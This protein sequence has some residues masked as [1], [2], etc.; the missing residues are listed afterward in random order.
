MADH[1]EYSPGHVEASG[2]T[3]RGHREANHPPTLRKMLRHYAHQP[4]STQPMADIRAPSLPREVPEL[5]GGYYHASRP[6]SSSAAFS[7][8]TAARPQSSSHPNGRTSTATNGQTQSLQNTDVRDFAYQ[9]TS[10]P[11]APLNITSSHD[12]E[13]DILLIVISEHEYGSWQLYPALFHHFKRIRIKLL[14][15][16]RSDALYFQIKHSVE[17]L[18]KRCLPSWRDKRINIEIL[19]SNP[20]RAK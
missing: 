12:P 8:G 15:N 19:P 17:K 16:K 10:L 1:R 9:K 4:I 2:R 7:S 5:S 18:L 3:S 11:E 20:D 6:A 14:A 13:K